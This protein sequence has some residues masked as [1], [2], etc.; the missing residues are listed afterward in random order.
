M[1]TTCG[2]VG[3]ND[4]AA[5]CNKRWHLKGHS[6]KDLYIAAHEELVGEYLEDHPEASEAEAYDLCADRAYDHMV[7][8]LADRGDHERKR[9]REEGR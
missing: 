1:V 8:R 6:M 3:H 2:W 5:W 4:P 7:D 9:R